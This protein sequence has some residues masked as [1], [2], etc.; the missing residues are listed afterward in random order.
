MS[1]IT[2]TT[3]VTIKEELV[4]PTTTIYW[5]PVT[6][7]GVV[8]WNTA[9]ERWV[10]GVYEGCKSTG[11]VLSLSI[12]ECLEHVFEITLPDGSTMQLPGAVMFLGMKAAFDRLGPLLVERRAAMSAP[13]VMPVATEPPP[14][15]PVVTDPPPETAP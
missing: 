7:T 8:Q 2:E 3:G 14:A 11:D 4:A 10:N 15:E 5:D 13:P 12:D 9:K 6:D 1:R